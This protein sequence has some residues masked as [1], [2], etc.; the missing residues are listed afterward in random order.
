MSHQLLD[1]T[2]ADL[3]G[4]YP[5]ALDVLASN[6]LDMFAGPE[7]LRAFGRALRLRTLLKAR[8]INPELFCRL[9]EERMAEQGD[10]DCPAAPGPGVNLFA[11]LPC[12]LKVPLE[13]AFK[14]FAARLPEER[15]TALKWII[16]GNANRV[17]DYADLADHFEDLSEMP[18][19]IITPG[20]NSFYHAPFV[21]RF[22]MTDLFRCVN[23]RMGDRHLAPLG[24]ADPAGH[25]TMLAM[26][27]LVLV[28]DNARL[29]N[30]PV[31]ARWADLLDPVHER[32]IAIRGYGDGT[33]C[34]TLLL[35]FFKDFG[36]GG[37]ERLGQNVRYGWHPSRMVKSAGNVREDGPA[38]SAMPLFFAKTIKNRDAVTIVW[39]DDGALVSPVTILVKA[40]K[41]DEL[42]DVVE[43]L[44]GPEVARICADAFFPTLH[45]EVDNRLPRNASFKWIGWDYIMGHDI[46]KLIAE[47]N[48]IFGRGFEGS[49]E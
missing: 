18:D 19:I 8:G 29:G 2:V 5:F 43:F 31:P 37:L 45:P 47:T 20:F 39:P 21:E 44:N 24:V 40:S 46:R 1:L 13:E 48:R 3:I 12:P 22:I 27:L 6:G 49:E 42:A 35:A 32:S 9:L 26:N 10:A 41:R 34:E 11:L 23:D 15:R 7:A 14:G 36:A 38:I 4:R 33:F 30:R 28:V 17:L 16:E 25:Y